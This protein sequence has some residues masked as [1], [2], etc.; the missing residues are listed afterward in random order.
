MLVAAL[1][2]FTW[3]VKGKRRYSSK[4]HSSSSSC[5]C[6]KGSVIV[7]VYLG[8]LLKLMVACQLLFSC[9]AASSMVIDAM[10]IPFAM[11]QCSFLVIGV[12]VVLHREKRVNTTQHRIP[13]R[14]ENAIWVRVCEWSVGRGISG[15]K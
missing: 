4:Y 12:Y 14:K 15:Q 1:V 3:S 13:Q 7:A 6:E 2:A 5:S 11:F 10:P 9:A 8:P